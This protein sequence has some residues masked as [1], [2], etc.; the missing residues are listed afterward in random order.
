MKLCR[1]REFLLSY[2]SNEPVNRT[3]ER[4]KQFLNEWKSIDYLQSSFCGGNDSTDVV[5][6]KANN[7]NQFLI[8]PKCRFFNKNIKQLEEH[9]DLSKAFDLIVMDP[10]WWN[11]YVRRTRKIRQ[12]N[13]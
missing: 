10:P 3:N 4:L 12:G 8:P 2:N 13:G 11:K 7:Q 6:F 5:V 1:E 9:A